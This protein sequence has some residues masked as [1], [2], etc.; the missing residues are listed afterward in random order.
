MLLV[1]VLISE[2]CFAENEYPAF[3]LLAP[4]YSPD[5]KTTI[6]VQRMP[7]IRSQDGLNICFAFS[8]WT[9]FQ[10]YQCTE[11]KKNCS[12][13]PSAESPS[14]LFLASLSGKSKDSPDSG[15]GDSYGISYSKGGNAFNS[16]TKLKDEGGGYA[17]SCY[18]LDQFISAHRNDVKEMNQAFEGIRK[19]FYEKNKTEGSICTDCLVKALDSEF[20]IKRD[21]QEVLKALAQDSF[22]K[23][24]FDIFLKDCPTVVEAP[25]MAIQGWPSKGEKVT[26]E[27]A[28]G[29]MKEV[30]KSG[31]PFSMGACLKNVPTSPNGLECTSSH[32]FVVSGFR[33]FCKPD[34][35][36]RESLKVANSWG[37]D[38][39]DKNNEGWVDAKTLYEHMYTGPN[40]L[41]WITRN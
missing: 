28:L 22:D 40:S 29:K 15:G 9:L 27:K 30:L 2:I 23:F 21:N 26:Y 8:S 37:Q 1:L 32:D 31:R 33:K 41:S 35:T 24:L 18:P 25:M 14:P 10:Q 36:C 12:A 13:V 39:Q 20:Q 38:W 6:E 3:S 16:L 19:D 4:N 7:P 5:K 17:E 11:Q 34:G